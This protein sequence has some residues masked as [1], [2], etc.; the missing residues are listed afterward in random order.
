MAEAKELVGEIKTDERGQRYVEVAVRDLKV[1]YICDLEGDPIADPAGDPV[2]EFEGQIVLDM[3]Q[4]SPGCTV[5]E[6]GD[7][8]VGFPPDHRLRVMV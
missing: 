5:V 1:G 8:T 2:L 6:F 3:V 4:E 7:T